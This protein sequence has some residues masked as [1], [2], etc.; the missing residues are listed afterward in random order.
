MLRPLT[1]LLLASGVAAAA[2]ESSR[3]S[4]SPD[5]ARKGEAQ[6]WKLDNGLEV[7]FVADRKAPVVAVSMVVRA[8]G[9]DEP[10]TQRGLAH[11]VE[12]LT[13]KGSRRI[14]ADGHA[15]MV[16]ALGGRSGADTTSDYTRFLD[17]VPSA[18]LAFALDLEAER[19]RNLTLNQAALDGEREV[20]KEELRQRLDGTLVE[21]VVDEVFKLAFT[22]H[23]Y[24]VVPGGTRAMLDGLTLADAQR[25]YDTWYQPNNVVLVVVGDADETSLRKAVQKSFGGI[26]RGPAASR[27]SVTEPAQAARQDLTL[28]LPVQTPM[29]VAV[30][31][32][33]PAR[34]AD[35][36]ALHVLGE[37]LAGG[38]LS[39]LRARLVT[40][41]KL[42]VE[43]DYEPWWLEDAGLL[44]F[45]AA[46]LP[47]SDPAKLRAA[48]LDECKRL[49][50]RA[51]SAAELA[52]AKNQLASRV[53]FARERP[54]ELASRLSD[55][56]I[57]AHEPRALKA[58]AAIDAVGA[59]DVQRVARKYLT[60]AQ[61]SFLTIVPATGKSDGETP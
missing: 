30:F 12:H 56:L 27:A 17:V 60:D 43:V 49:R 61:V 33:P 24:R 58:A 42:A 16:A 5:G 29:V 32:A 1:A 36:T 54:S 38:E 35:R 19:L 3:P 47:S 57:N 13:W 40:S 6:R 9:K 52:R 7:V 26:P 41:D 8:G 44:T 25:Y 50:D 37:I 59:A 53:A 51:P 20:I 28:T 23:P 10:A 48:M 4:P 31:H 45:P 46:Y 21:R 39:R 34:D 55:D 11:L 18:A 2:P 14:P 22:S 15:R